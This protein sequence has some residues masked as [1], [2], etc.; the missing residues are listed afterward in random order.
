MACSFVVPATL[1]ANTYYFSHSLGDDSNPG[2]VA[3]PKKNI[4]EA[5][6][7]MKDGNTVVFRK[8]DQWYMPLYS[9][10][11]TNKSNFTLGAYGPDSLAAP[12]L[13][14]MAI[15][16]DASWTYDGSGIWR[17]SL[18]YDS[19]FRV[20]V[21]GTSRINVKYETSNGNSKSYLNTTAEYYFDES[22]KVLYV[23]TGSSTVRP[24]SVEVVPCSAAYP[25]GASTIL[26]QN[27]HKVTLTGLDIRGGSKWNVIYI[28][29]PSDSITITNCIVGR[30]SFYA[31][32]IVVTN[33]VA[34]SD[35]VSDI[36]I[37]NNVVDKGWTT[38]ENNTTIILHGDGIFFLD[39]V[40]RGLIQGNTVRNWGHVGITL[41]AYDTTAPVIH[42][43]HHVVVDHNDISAGASAYM[44]G[45]DVSGLPGL[46]TYNIVK[47]NYIHDYTTTCHALG[48]NNVFFSNIFSNVVSTSLTYLHQSDQPYGLDLFPWP[49]H[50][51]FIEAR[52]NWILNNTFY[53]T[54]GWAIW[55]GSNGG[56][57]ANVTNNK[58]ANNILLNYGSHDDLNVAIGLYI[59]ST[60]GGVT[61][62]RHND[63]YQSSA[64]YAAGYRT[65]AVF[66]TASTLN[67]A[68]LCGSDCNA[69]LQLSPVFDS[70]FGLT[71]A[72]PDTLKTGGIDYSSFMSPTYMQASE[73]T[74]YYGH[75]WRSDPSVGAIQ[76]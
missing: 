29:S 54:G 69:N 64:P 39:A 32:G 15:L 52:D 50:T 60:A 17:Y 28:N 37:T 53:N 74:D 19:L 3:L 57:N 73:F 22:A 34:N 20:F 26:M 41:T 51:S 36:T 30:A 2:T 61:Y 31:G 62:V 5:L 56:V 44:H 21:N 24:A 4:G 68:P 76:Y 6:N 70:W 43:V 63:F 12:V 58:I 48:S 27:T 23:Y 16:T 9:L 35:Y 66:Y 38:N 18:S 8:G 55:M 72:S 10:D 33:S 65:S 7:Y 71:A 49:Y 13:A 11:L 1:S 45:F 67:G 59:D 46:T 75:V 25:A 40:E 47:R 42:G 14:G